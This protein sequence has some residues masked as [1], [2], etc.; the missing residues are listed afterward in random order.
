MSISHNTT[1]PPREAYVDLFADDSFD[2]QTDVE[3]SQVS[4]TNQLFNAFVAYRGNRTPEST[5]QILARFENE[6]TSY[7]GFQQNVE[8]PTLNVQG[9][10]QA[11]FDHQEITNPSHPTG[12][13]YMLNRESVLP[14]QSKL[15]KVAAVAR[16]KTQQK[17]QQRYQSS[18]VGQALSYL[19]GKSDDASV[20]GPSASTRIQDPVV[21][22][23]RSP[24][25]V[26]Q[27]EPEPVSPKQ[28]RIR[29][30]IAH[31]ITTARKEPTGI[32]GWLARKKASISNIAH[33]A[34][35]Y[36]SNRG[37]KALSPA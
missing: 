27:Y 6:E 28:L 21:K 5:S 8:E 26:T 29:N 36:V 24:L 3:P 9:H 30:D 16:E 22:V 37:Y 25:P 17:S 18:E 19:L 13:E 12:I 23:T 20:F 11:V 32:K 14:N 4:P 10:I 33:S 31:G 7:Q 34:V 2:F 15:E 35:A 1:T